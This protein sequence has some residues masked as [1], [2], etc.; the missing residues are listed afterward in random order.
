LFFPGIS[1]HFQKK[2]AASAQEKQ[3]TGPFSDPALPYQKMIPNTALVF[4][5]YNVNLSVLKPEYPPDCSFKRHYLALSFI[6]FIFAENP[7][8]GVEIKHAERI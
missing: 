2:C 7:P 6:I 8:D 3:R 5:G 4:S 1:E